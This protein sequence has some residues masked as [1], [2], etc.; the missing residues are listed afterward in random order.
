MSALLDG[1]DPKT[2]LEFLN[3]AS[4]FP[5][6]PKGFVPPSLLDPNYVPPTNF[7]RLEVFTYIMMVLMTATVAARLWARKRIKGMVFGLDDWLAI[8]GLVLSLGLMVIVILLIRIGGAGRHIY[9][10]S[11]TRIEKTQQVRCPRVVR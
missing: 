7:I 3:Y 6:F 9:D 1:Q 2:I 4:T 8:P 10:I 11:F 5:D